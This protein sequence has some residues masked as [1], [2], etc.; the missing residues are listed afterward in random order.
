MANEL[1]SL[2]DI[3]GCLVELS[4]LC[5]SEVVALDFHPMV[6]VELFDHLRPLVRRVGP[7]TRREHDF[8][9][10]CIHKDLVCFDSVDRLLAKHDSTSGRLLGCDVQLEVAI[11]VGFELRDRAKGQAD[12]V[13]Y[14]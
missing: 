11:F 12:S 4:Y 5:G 3:L 13:L 9:V 14:T 1:L 8:G 10:R 6:I 7:I 2:D